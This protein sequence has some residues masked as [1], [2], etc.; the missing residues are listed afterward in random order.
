MLPA[1]AEPTRFFWM[2]TSTRAA[3]VVFR[4]WNTGEHWVK[5]NLERLHQNAG[6]ASD[7]FRQENMENE[8]LLCIYRHVC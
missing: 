3:V 6:Q 7:V 5:Q 4:T 1:I 2:L 8:A